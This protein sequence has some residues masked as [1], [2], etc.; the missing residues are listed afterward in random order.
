[1]RKIFALILC[2]SFFVSG[3]A[4]LGTISMSKTNR[5]SIGMT[6]PEVQ[7]VLGNPSRTELVGDKTVWRYY[8]HQYCVGFVP[9]YLVFDKNTQKLDSWTDYYTK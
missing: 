4:S 1:M 9:Y 2:L 5:L 7:K 6:M 3:C 8:L